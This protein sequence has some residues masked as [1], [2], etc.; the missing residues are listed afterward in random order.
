VFSNKVFSSSEVNTEADDRSHKAA[1]GTY[2]LSKPFSAASS[3]ERAA[4]RTV[5]PY[6]YVHLY[7]LTYVLYVHAMRTVGSTW[8]RALT[9]SSGLP[10]TLKTPYPLR[11]PTIMDQPTSRD[12]INQGSEPIVVCFRDSVCW[13]A[14]TNRH[15]EFHDYGGRGAFFSF[16][17]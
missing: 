15:C 2:I 14:P 10:C 16:S 9:R 13:I 17:A 11:C 5:H 8:Y 3:R 6:T 4:H 7:V 12:D 1:W